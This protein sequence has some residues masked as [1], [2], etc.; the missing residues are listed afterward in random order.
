MGH[1]SLP[2][3]SRIE[4]V[5]KYFLQARASGKTRR[6]VLWHG[7][8]LVHTGEAQPE[9]EKLVPSILVGDGTEEVSQVVKSIM[10]WLEGQALF[11]VKKKEGLA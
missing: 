4:S 2:T 5:A 11:G 1:E 10:T 6:L 9:A 3:L 7:L 8:Y